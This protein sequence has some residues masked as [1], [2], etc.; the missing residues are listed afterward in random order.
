MSDKTI[1]LK[2]D[3]KVKTSSEKICMGD[4]G[5]IYCNVGTTRKRCFLGGNR[6]AGRLLDTW[7]FVKLD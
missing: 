4:L 2:M 7:F 3:A 1:Y 5:K 6:I